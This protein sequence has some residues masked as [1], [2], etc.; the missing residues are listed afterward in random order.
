[1]KRWDQMSRIFAVLMVMS[2]TSTVTIPDAQAQPAPFAQG[3]V[4]SL[5]VKFPPDN[6]AALFNSTIVWTFNRSLPFHN[7]TLPQTSR[8]FLDDIVVK[9]QGDYSIDIADGLGNIQET[10]RFE[11]LITRTG[12]WSK[13]LSGG[14]LSVRVR[15]Q[16][17]AEKLSFRLTRI[18]YDFDALA[19]K[20][21]VGAINGLTDV[22]LY[23]GP[24]SEELARIAPSVAK[25]EYIKDGSKFTCSGFLVDPQR[26]VT[27]AHCIDSQALCD[28]AIA[29]FNYQKLSH[30]GISL[31]QQYRCTDFLGADKTIDAAAFTLAERPVDDD[32][33]RQPIVFGETPLSSSEPLLLIQHPG[34]SPKMVSVEGC[35]ASTLPQT[36]G[37]DGD[38]SVSNFEHGCDTE[39]GSSGSPLLRANGKLVGLHKI[40]HG[41]EA[42]SGRHNTAVDANVL[43]AWLQKTEILPSSDNAE[44]AI[45]AASENSTPP[46][47]SIES[48]EGNAGQGMP[49]AECDDVN[50][51]NC[52]EQFRVPD[53]LKD[54]KPLPMP[55]VDD[56]DPTEM[57]GDAPAEDGESRSEPGSTGSGTTE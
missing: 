37:D 29:I 43:R 49:N 36:P 39:Q 15:G 4:V 33:G 46:P 56:E 14:S 44:E 3:P 52:P 11:E 31:G 20:S 17:A 26:M 22:A 24:M 51:D 47:V 7:S 25:L 41:A 16:D 9:G 38:L 13:V 23:T 1:M 8:I 32:A 5:D 45:M 19:E 48:E 28:T 2:V 40:G 53:D 34:G 55:T 10:F 50:P 54:A 35:M 21:L 12:I 30:G 57:K 27:N 42:D 18:A 6:A